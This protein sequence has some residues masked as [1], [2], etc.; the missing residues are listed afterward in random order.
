MYTCIAASHGEVMTQLNPLRSDWRR[1]GIQFCIPDHEMKAIDTNNRGKTWDCLNATVAEWLKWNF[2]E[3]AKGQ[4]KSNVD[5]LIRVVDTI[6]HQHALK[7]A[8]EGRPCNMLLIMIIIL[9]CIVYKVKISGLEE[10]SAQGQLIKL[11][12]YNTLLWVTNMAHYRSN[13]HIR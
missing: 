12:L 6:D 8:D 5:W 7:L 2:T 10:H 11:I 3:N 4:V 13:F 1:L 9:L